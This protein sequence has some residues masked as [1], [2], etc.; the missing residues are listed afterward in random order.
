MADRSMP[1]SPN[2]CAPAVYALH[3]SHVELDSAYWVYCA[4]LRLVSIEELTAVS[5]HG[6]TCHQDPDDGSANRCRFPE[7]ADLTSPGGCWRI[8]EEFQ[9]LAALRQRRDDPCSTSG[10][11][12]KGTRK[13][14]ASSVFFNKCEPTV[15]PK[16]FL[17]LR[18]PF[19]CQSTVSPFQRCRGGPIDR[20]RLEA[21]VFARM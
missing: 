6:P 15:S 21:L 3:G 2:L 1:S 10:V 5:D 12:K 8:R 9:E 13:L 11:V 16:R 17:I 18:A 14:A 19:T 4:K 20:F 7:Y